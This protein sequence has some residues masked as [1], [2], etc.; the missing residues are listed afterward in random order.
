MMVGRL[1]S[2]WD[3]KISGAMLNFEGVCKM[4]LGWI[5]MKCA[6]LERRAELSARHAELSVVSQKKLRIMVEW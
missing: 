6:T 2:L 1:L 4:R 5:V 3:G